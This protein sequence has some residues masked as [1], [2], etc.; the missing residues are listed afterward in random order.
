MR[1]LPVAS[2]GPQ[3][4]RHSSH[5]PSSLIIGFR[6]FPSSVLK[7]RCRLVPSRR[8]ASIVAVEKSDPEP[9]D[10][11]KCAQNWFY[12]KIINYKSCRLNVLRIRIVRSEMFCRRGVVSGM[13]AKSEPTEGD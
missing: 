13:F 10:E 7:F 5:A 8:G 4:K 6:K 9:R 3:R 2:V 11:P 1:L 12:M